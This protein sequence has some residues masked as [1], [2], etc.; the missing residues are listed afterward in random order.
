MSRLLPP[1]DLL[2]Q[3]DGVESGLR[4]GRGARTAGLIVGAAQVAVLVVNNQ[5]F[6]ELVKAVE[7]PGGGALLEQWPLYLCVFLL[8]LSFL[9][10]GWTRFWL[11]ESRQPFRY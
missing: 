9:A 5:W 1:R 10:V 7:S 4:R 3:I 2:Q 8:A 6:G 11:R